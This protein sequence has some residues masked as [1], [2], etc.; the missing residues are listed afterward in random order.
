[1]SPAVSYQ[2]QLT[3]VVVQRLRNWFESDG[4]K[5]PSW[6]Y[7]VIHDLILSAADFYPQCIKFK[8]VQRP[9]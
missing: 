3:Y 4:Y 1:M 8:E 9:P 7:H 5:E 2:L 6:G